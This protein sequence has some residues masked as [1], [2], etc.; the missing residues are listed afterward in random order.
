MEGGFLEG[1]RY[2]TSK[3]AAGKTHSSRKEGSLQMVLLW[4]SPAQ[5]LL[6]DVRRI[7]TAKMGCSEKRDQEA[8]QCP[9]LYFHHLSQGT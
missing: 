1:L 3:D 8:A 7:F 6:A 5:P 2:K 9:G 4:H